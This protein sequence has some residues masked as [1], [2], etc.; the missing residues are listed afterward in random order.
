[1]VIWHFLRFSDPQLGRKLTF[2]DT[3]PFHLVSNWQIAPFFFSLF[4]FWNDFPLRSIYLRVQLF[5]NLWH[6]RERQDRK[7][8]ETNQNHKRIAFVTFD[9]NSDWCL[10]LLRCLTS[11]YSSITFSLHRLIY[12][13]S[14]AISNSKDK[15]RKYQCFRLDKIM[16]NISTLT[17][18]NRSEISFNIR[19]RFQFQ[20]DAK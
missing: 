5:L 14:M 10:L 20:S 15:P 17:V 9:S 6:K 18:V 2:S 11:I 4:F 19:Q 3:P 13:A 12:S 7:A 8:S 1:M 16:L